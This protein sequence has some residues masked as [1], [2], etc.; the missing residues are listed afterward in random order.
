MFASYPLFHH[1]KS[2]DHF[3]SEQCFKSQIKIQKVH[4]ERVVLGRGKETRKRKAITSSSYIYS[5]EASQNDP[6]KP[7]SN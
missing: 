7:L 1:L 3:H 2:K 6:E 4:R 5:L